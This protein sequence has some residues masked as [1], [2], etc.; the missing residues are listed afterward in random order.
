MTTQQRYLPFGAVRTDAGAI[1]QTDF[2]FTFQRSLP[3][4]GLMDYDARFYL[5]A[6]GRFTQPDTLVPGAGNPQSWN[7]YSYV[8]NNPIRFV[9]PTGHTYEPP[10]FLCDTL[11]LDYSSAPLFVQGALD[12]GL[13]TACA[14]VGCVTNIETHTVWGPTKEEYASRAFIGPM[15]DVVPTAVF[16]PPRRLA[17]IIDAD[18]METTTTLGNPIKDD[19]FVTAADDI[20]GIETSEELAQRLTLIDNEGKFLRGP[21]GI[22]EFDTPTTGLA[23]P[24]NRKNPGFVGTGKTA[25]GARE[26][27]IKNLKL[28]KLKNLLRRIIE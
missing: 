18:L 20:A 17:R 2:G 25:G 14:F 12:F 8:Q 26:F 15:V 11:L 4:A 13:S 5:P 6:L 3:E 27:I 9:D 23:S 24:I 1:T 21:F 7:R 22:L 16:V 28:D 19:V 10:C